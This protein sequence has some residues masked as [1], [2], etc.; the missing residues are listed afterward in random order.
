MA[1][2]GGVVDGAGKLEP[3]LVPTDEAWR[4]IGC[5]KTTGFALL[6]AKK[7]RGRKL[8]TKTLVEVESIREFVNSLPTVGEAA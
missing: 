1:K 3:L 7:L 8:G 5:G 2:N 6:K 4:A